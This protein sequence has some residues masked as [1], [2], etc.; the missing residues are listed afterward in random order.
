MLNSVAIR[1][2]AAVRAGTLATP[3]DGALERPQL[4][5]RTVGQKV[6]GGSLTSRV[7]LPRTATMPSRRLSFDGV[8][9]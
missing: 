9:L 7:F 4:P 1:N 6:T 3:M 2:D 8:L 5:A